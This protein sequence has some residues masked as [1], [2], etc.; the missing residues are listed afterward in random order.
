MAATTS[1][2]APRNKPGPQHSTL[3]PVSRHLVPGSQLSKH[4]CCSRA[5]K[6]V[7]PKSKSQAW[8]FV[9]FATL[10]TVAKLKSLLWPLPFLSRE[11]PEA[12]M[13]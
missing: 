2:C 3:D 5:P 4:S 7:G 9:P 6:A 8:V 11:G 10:A 13:V 12:S 1:H